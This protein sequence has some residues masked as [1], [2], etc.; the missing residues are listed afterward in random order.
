MQQKTLV[1]DVMTYSALI[2]ACE[3]DKRLEQALG[4]FDAL[5]QQSVVPNVITYS[6]LITVC[7]KSKQFEWALEL[8]EA[9]Q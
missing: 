5:E 7:K 2:S 9:M 4:L 8:F 6:A 3:D 1:P